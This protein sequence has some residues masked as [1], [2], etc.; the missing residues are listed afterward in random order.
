[1]K[2]IHSDPDKYGFHLT[3]SD[4]YHP[5]ETKDVEVSSIDDIASFAVRNGTTYKELKLLNS[6]LRSTKLSKRSS[7]KKYIVKIV[8]H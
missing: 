3:D 5:I 6:W 2:L 8:K 1:M 7:G 4:Y